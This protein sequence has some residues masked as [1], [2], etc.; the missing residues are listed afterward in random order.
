MNTMNEQALIFDIKRDS[1]E[2]G[3]GIRT[4]VFFKGCP[5]SCVWCHNPEGI[6]KNSER[7][8]NG[9][10][11]GYWIGLEELLY[12]V[13]QDK[14]FYRSSNG[15]VTLSGGEPTQQMAFA[16]RF[17]K[18]LKRE[19][20]HTAIETCGLFNYKH[21]CSKLLPWLDLIYFDLKLID[22][23]QSRRFTGCS[24][25]LILENFSRLIHKAK[26]PVIPRIPLVPGITDSSSNL[27]GLANYLSSQGITT[28][29]LLPYNPLWHDKL[30]RLGKKSA[31]QHT[32]FMTAEERTLSLN[33]F[34]N[35]NTS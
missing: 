19:S 6:E 22:D 21:F 25:G 5:M 23:F 27:S 11:I 9:N 26:I 15:G 10:T 28:C 16:H 12:R 1:T 20:I 30:K 8:D 34:C 7:D 3:P 2:D 4:T 31:Y 32:R 14:P 33:T 13:H 17:L 35:P 24:N 29:T 18:A